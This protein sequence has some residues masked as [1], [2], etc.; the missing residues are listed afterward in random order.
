[1]SKSIVIQEHLRPA[2]RK[3]LG[4]EDYRQQEQLLT[5][6]DRILK[7]RGMEKRFVELSVKVYQ[8]AAIG[9]VQLKDL[10][11]HSERSEKALRCTV[12]KNILGE[13]FREMSVRLAQCELFRWFCRLPE[14]EEV[15]VP[16]KSTLQGYSTW[17]PHE[18]MGQVLRQL[19]E[20][21]GDEDRAKEIG[22]ENEL[23]MDVALGGHDVPESEHSLS[24]GLGIAE[25]CGAN[26]H[27]GDHS[28]PEAWATDANA[29]TGGVF[30][31]N[32]RAGDGDE[33][34]V[35]AQARKQESAQ[36]RATGDEKDLQDGERTLAP[37][38]AGT[39]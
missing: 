26:A 31:N 35:A 6:A 18:E 4:C 38:P 19:R 29:R 3:V 13:D 39:R 17:L 37:I 30:G 24:G 32:E 36:E 1:M 25:G 20:A 7:E 9:P 15:R 10:M 23:D 2:L 8:E 5:R 34:G 33:R 11:R 28:D 22:L 21:M 27:E 14:L 16:G 12:L